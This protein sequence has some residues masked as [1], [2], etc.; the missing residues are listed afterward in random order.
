MIYTKYFCRID[1]EYRSNSPLSDNKKI[2]A[3]LFRLEK[4]LNLENVE[5]FWGNPACG[6]YVHFSADKMTNAKKQR[7]K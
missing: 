6:P 1:F 5:T 3:F 7:K 2:D 4:E